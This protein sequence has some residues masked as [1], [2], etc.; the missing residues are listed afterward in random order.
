MTKSDFSF[1]Q[2][3]KIRALKYRY[4]TSTSDPY[5]SG[6]ALASICD[7][8]IRVEDDLEIF[9]RTGAMH[10]TVF[11]RSDLVPHLV[12]TQLSPKKN[13]TLI[14]GNSDFDFADR[15]VLPMNTFNRFFLQN[16]MISDSKSIFTLPVGVE[17]LS[18][19]INGLPGNLVTKIA[20]KEKSKTV[21]VGPF[22]PT[23]ESRERLMTIARLHPKVFDCNFERISP[24]QF[25]IKM[26][27]YKYVACPRGNGMDSHRLWE[28]LY[29]GSIP[30]V[31]DSSWSRSLSYYKL[32]LIQVTSWD[33]V[34]AAIDTFENTHSVIS[35]EN[36][37]AL[38]IP[39]WKNIL[40]TNPLASY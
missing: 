10:N 9:E 35:P 25:A 34:E 11:C 27:R 32:P 23:H 17:N 6:D 5:L 33:E 12:K 31:L 29:R 18:I 36:I 7:F 2:R 30:I 16:S 40:T 3:I 24:K 20:W 21:L 26:N 8:Y 15:E 38:W 14:A 19:G 22:S 39:F 28:T 13:R 4:R 37:P 1:L